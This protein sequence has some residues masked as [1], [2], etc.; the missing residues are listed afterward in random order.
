MSKL[1][2]FETFV[3]TVRRYPMLPSAHINGQKKPVIIL[4]DDLPVTNGKAAH[5]RLCECLRVL[6]CSTHVPT[7]ILVTEYSRDDSNDIKGC[8][9]E[10]LLSTLQKAGAH[11]VYLVTF[12]PQFLNDY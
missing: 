8:H 5:E 1:D 9:V 6:T 10:E 3:N 11:K 2:E 7:V 4:I 12:L